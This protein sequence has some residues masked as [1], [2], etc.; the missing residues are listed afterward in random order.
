[1]TFLDYDYHIIT[2]KRVFQQIQSLY[3]DGHQ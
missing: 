1:M 3:A 2:D